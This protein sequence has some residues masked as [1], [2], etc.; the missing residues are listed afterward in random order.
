MVRFTNENPFARQYRLT[1][2]L[3]IAN[4]ITLKPITQ[5]L[6]KL[7]DDWSSNRVGLAISIS[8]PQDYRAVFTLLYALLTI[9]LALSLVVMII[10]LRLRKDSSLRIAKLKLILEVI[11]T[12]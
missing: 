1:S 5:R 10:R 7:F 4:S 12:I 11:K 3:G 6:E 9:S 8:N 2:F